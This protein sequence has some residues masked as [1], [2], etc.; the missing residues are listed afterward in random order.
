MTLT[1]NERQ[2]ARGLARVMI[3][4]ADRPAIAHTV[5]V[6]LVGIYALLLWLP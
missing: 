5:L 2:H 4:L 6:L 3:W 1:R